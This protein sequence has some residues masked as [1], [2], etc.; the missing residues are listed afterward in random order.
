MT[1]KEQFEKIISLW[2]ENAYET[3]YY[4]QKLVGAG[5]SDFRLRSKSDF[6]QLPFMTKENLR[7]FSPMQRTNAR[8]ED[9]LSY[10]SS[11]GT[12]GTKTVYA[13]SREDKK[14]QE[15]VTKKLYTSLGIGP[16]DIGMIAVPINSG[17]MGHSM[18]WQYMVMG[19]GFYCVDAP[20]YANIK[21]ALKNLPVTVMSTLPSLALL[22]NSSEEDREIA[23]QSSIRM[24]LAGGDIISESRRRQIEELYN[25][26]LYNSFGMSE[27]FGPT[28]N[29]GTDQ[30]G[31]RYCDDVLFMEILDPDT[32]EEVPDGETGIACYTALWH[33]ASPLIRYRTDD[34]ICKS[35][36]VGEDGLPRFY[37]KG[38]L[39]FSRK[40]G[41]GKLVT[42]Y[43]IERVLSKHLYE[44]SYYI[45]VHSDGTMT[46]HMVNER[47]A[48]A[49]D[50]EKQLAEDMS[51]LMRCKVH[52]KRNIEKSEF[53]Y[54]MHTFRQE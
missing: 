22:M 45:G 33:K 1:R 50:S 10:F 38:R 53:D 6:K 12:T 41:A 20:D 7:D 11:S 25:A 42:G 18:I 4:R 46:L 9:I 13:F 43:D 39:T 26:R 21:F 52:I 8:P 5:L 27:I 29:E 31:F 30:D 17:N 2:E 3:E 44:S 15:Y 19:G 34:L 16:G 54:K 48:D 51:E 36:K 28:A 23:R 37:H 32:L 24:L 14:V 40:N 49:V 47:L 35:S